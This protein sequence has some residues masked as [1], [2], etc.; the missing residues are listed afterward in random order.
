MTSAQTLLL[1]F[2]FSTAAAHNARTVRSCLGTVEFRVDDPDA[3]PPR[4]GLVGLPTR[5]TSAPLGSASCAT[6]VTVCHQSAAI[7]GR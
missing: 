4:R 6:F 3:R 2:A 7:A 5:A 1:F